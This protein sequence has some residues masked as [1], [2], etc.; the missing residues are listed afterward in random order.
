MGEEP[1][2]MS[3]SEETE[4]QD[5]IT[6]RGLKEG[7]TVWEASQ[8]LKAYEEGRIV[9]LDEVTK[10]RPGARAILNEIMQAPEL[11]VPDHRQ[12]DGYRRIMRGKGFQIIATMN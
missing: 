2:V 3:L 12:P 9:I 11:L 4:G 8:L 1:I 7:L 5:F 6:W 10:T